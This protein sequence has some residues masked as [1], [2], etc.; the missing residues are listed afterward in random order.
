MPKFRKKPVFIHAYRI[1]VPNEIE[2]LEWK[3]KGERGDWRIVG[4]KG[5]EYFCKD[6]IFRL[7]YE[8]VDEEGERELRESLEE[9]EKREEEC[10]G[11]DIF[12]KPR[13]TRGRVRDL[14]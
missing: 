13:P 6:E 11:E 8:A 10:S 5:E 2:T 9:I 1:L 14:L 12:Y 3:M 7:T 4:V